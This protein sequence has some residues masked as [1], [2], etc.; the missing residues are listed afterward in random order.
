[1]EKA[2][3]VAEQFE[4]VGGRMFMTANNSYREVPRVCERVTIVKDLHEQC[5]HVGVSKLYDMLRHYYYW[6]HLFETCR[7][8][9]G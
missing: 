1:M 7:M 9:C 4:I 5:G 2:L 3:A 6:P 8:I